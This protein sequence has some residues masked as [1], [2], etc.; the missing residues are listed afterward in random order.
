MK[1]YIFLL[2]TLVFSLPSYSQLQLQVTHDPRVELLSVVY[3]LSGAYEYRQS[4]Y[5]SYREDVD[6]YFEDFKDHDAVQLA[7][8]LRKQHIGFDAVMNFAL[9]L[10]W[11]KQ[12]T[13]REDVL[14]DPNDRW[15]QENERKM[16][17]ALNSF[18]KKTKFSVFYSIHENL[19]SAMTEQMQAIVNKLDVL[20]FDSFFEPR[21]EK[22][23]HVMTS[24]LNGPQNYSVTINSSRGGA[25]STVVMGGCLPDDANMPMFVEADAF[26]ILVHEFCHV[27]CNDLN[28]QHWDEMSAQAATVFSPVKAKLQS[29]A[30]GTPK[31][32]MDETFVRS[33]VINYMKNHDPNYNVADA[34]FEQTQL[35]F[36]LANDVTES[37]FRRDRSRYPTMAS[38]MPVLVRDINAFDLAQYRKNI[39]SKSAHL[40]SCSVKDGSEIDASVS[41]IVFTF[42]KPMSGNVALHINEGVVFPPLANRTPPFSWSKSNKT[43]TVYVVLAPNT[44]YGFCVHE[45]FSTEDGYPLDQ[46]YYYTFSTK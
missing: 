42:D 24:I 2:L 43:L 17:K 41:S 45:S 28:S 5:S 19:Y 1:K 10:N 12:L 13:L 30:Y 33:S 21:E 11:D 7:Y 9:K 14:D 20:W 44:T 38:Y 36:L 16:L 39:D 37:L 6:K 25:E 3:Y 4:Y 8:E 29:I 46:N 31:I 18:V 15:S 26:P 35:G 23:F 32:M 27:Y 22:N 34:L 40:L